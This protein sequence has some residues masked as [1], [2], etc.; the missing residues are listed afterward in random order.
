MGY[1][2]RT[3]RF[4]YT[5]WI[6]DLYSAEFPYSQAKIVATELYDYDKD[7]LETKSLIGDKAYAK[8]EVMM[9][10]MFTEAMNREHV[11][12]A[13]YSKLADWHEPIST[14]PEKKGKKIKKDRKSGDV[15]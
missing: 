15:E 2:I 1:T 13:N 14:T 11:Q 4:R 10:K 8:E 7:P 6:G 12:Y 3:K 5:E 9:K